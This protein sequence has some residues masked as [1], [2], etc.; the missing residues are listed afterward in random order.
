MQEEGIE[1]NEDLLR[2]K[3]TF[4]SAASLFILEE[5]EQR[6]WIQNADIVN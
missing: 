6:Q 1:E 5:D 4:I 2:E 3:Q